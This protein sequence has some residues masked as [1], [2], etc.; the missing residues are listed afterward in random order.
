MQSTPTAYL[1]ANNNKTTHT[2]SHLFRERDTPL[3]ILIPDRLL[4]RRPDYPLLLFSP[5]SAHG[6][7]ARSCDAVVAGA[8]GKGGSKVAWHAGWVGGCSLSSLLLHQ[9]G[10]M[11]EGSP[12]QPRPNTFVSYTMNYHSCLLPLLLGFA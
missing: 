4:P 2:Q 11:E 1:T 3:P 6:A 5:S 9:C 7:R 12:G 10:W 8:P